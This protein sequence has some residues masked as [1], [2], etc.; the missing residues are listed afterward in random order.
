MSL[1]SLNTVQWTD[2]LP[3]IDAIWSIKSSVVGSSMRTLLLQ[4]CMLFWTVIAAK[5]SPKSDSQTTAVTCDVFFPFWNCQ[6]WR[7][8]L[9]TRFIRINHTRITS[10]F[11]LKKCFKIIYI[12]NVI[13]VGRSDVWIESHRNPFAVARVALVDRLFLTMTSKTNYAVENNR[14]N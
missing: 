2:S 5:Y 6:L 10:K 7:F 4:K 14:T 12:S 13:R 11:L 9:I 3:V 8:K 1:G